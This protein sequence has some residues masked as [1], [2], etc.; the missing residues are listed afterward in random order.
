MIENSIFVPIAACEERFIEQTVRSALLKAKHPEKIYFG[1]FNNI[2]DK[3]KSLL[4]NDFIVNNSQIFYTEIATP[5]PM[6]TGF[7]RMNASLLQFK[8]FEY[9]FQTDAHTLFTEN[10][11]EQLIHY[12]N[13]IKNEN[14]IDENKI[15]LSASSPISWFSF[16]NNPYRIMMNR[17]G[18]GLVEVDPYDLE[19]DF[20]SEIKE[21]AVSITI[22]YDGFQDKT[23]FENNIGF[24][25]TYGNNKIDSEL[26]Y[27]ETN[28]VHAS[29][30]FS[31]ANLVRDILHDPEDTFDGDQ[32][33]YGIRLLSRGYRIFSPKYPVISCL[34]K[35]DEQGVFDKEFNW[36][37]KVYTYDK[38]AGNY[39]TY[40]KNKCEYFFEKMIN[41]EYYGYWG[42]PDKQS[43][44]FAKKKID[45]PVQ[46]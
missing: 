28:C 38:N 13:K 25:I 31:K 23:L 4:S 12:F 33:N 41:G 8:E 46:N 29:F 26:E 30:M 27:E 45:Y 11:D 24:P 2:I 18:L 19:K 42:T 3:N 36:R 14:N 37:Y 32:T 44:E 21:G 34:N 15:I 1:I 43:L 10:W 5:C 7:A 35:Q 20:S 6:G 9:M 16:E 17:P 22:K 39:I 40:K